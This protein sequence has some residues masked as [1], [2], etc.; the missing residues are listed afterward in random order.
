MCARNTL[1]F[2]TSSHSLFSVKAFY[3]IPQMSIGFS[4]ARLTYYLVIF[5]S[6]SDSVN[7]GT[8]I[9]PFYSLHIL[10]LCLQCYFS[11]YNYN[12]TSFINKDA[13][14]YIWWTRIFGTWFR[15]GLIQNVVLV[16]WNDYLSMLDILDFSALAYK[17]CLCLVL[18]QI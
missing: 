17:K 7:S 3:S 12:V 4:G 10:S 5:V 18:K 15:I 16:S 13:I 8:D 14:A 1:D 6:S 11:V 9:C 2:V